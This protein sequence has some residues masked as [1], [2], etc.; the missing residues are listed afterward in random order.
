[1]ANST[2]VGNDGEIIMPE[3]NKLE[4]KE[5]STSIYSHQQ[6][7]QIGMKQQTILSILTS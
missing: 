6:E 1:M 4:F 5:L 2:F 3:Q 7:R